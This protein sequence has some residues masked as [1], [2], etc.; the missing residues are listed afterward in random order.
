MSNAKS[1]TPYGWTV[2]IWVLILAFNYGYH[3][4]ALNQLQAVLT[5]R[6]LTVDPSDRGT[7]YG[8]PLCIPMS[9]TTFSAVTSIFNVGGLIGSMG[10]NVAMDRYG[11]RGATRLSGMMTAIGALLMAVSSSVG[12]LMFGRSLVGVGAGLG[13]CVGPVFISEIA[14]A[15]I[16]GSVGVL[17]Q[18]AI[19]LGIMFTQAVG[20]YLATPRTWRFVLLLSA[21]LALAQVLLGSLAA[22]SPVFLGHRGQPAEQKAVAA[23]LWGAGDADEVRQ[24]LLEEEEEQRPAARVEPFGVREVFRARELRTALIIVIFAML[25]QQ[26]SGINAVLYYSN[27]ILSK[28]LPDMGPYVSLGITVVNVFMTFP[29][30]FLIE[31]IG[32]KKLLQASVAGAII[33]HIA[34]GFG[35]NSGAVW[36]ASF[37]VMTFVTSFAIGLGPVPFVL[38][39]EVAPPHATSTLSTI[40]LSFNWIVNFLVALV[41]LPLRNFLAG[42]DATQEGKVFYVFAA[43]LAVTAGV[44][45]RVYR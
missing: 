8:L 30:I 21:L 26:T 19:V 24:A 32:R 18:L 33:S 13:I 16:R 9:D 15:K 40:G 14:P 20:L 17:T 5:C 27:D 37:A 42:G 23:R 45:L 1:F 22:E 39:S 34:I 2:C 35:L 12:P 7:H 3:I 11:R 25:S 31:R 28:A 38:I 10:A 44:L 41:F 29:P 43:V 4:S 36:L 6:D